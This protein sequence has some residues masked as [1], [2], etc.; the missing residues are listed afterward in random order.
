MIVAPWADSKWGRRD[1]GRMDASR[2]QGEFRSFSRSSGSL[3]EGDAQ[4]IK[5]KGLGAALLDGPTD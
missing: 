2:R 5:I 1:A 4:V 3:C